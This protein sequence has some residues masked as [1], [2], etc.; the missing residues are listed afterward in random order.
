MPNTL[1]RMETHPRWW[2]ASALLGLFCL[3]GSLAAWLAGEAVGE[4]VGLG[5]LCTI[6][7]FVS[8]FVT[9]HVCDGPAPARGDSHGA[10]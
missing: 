2:R 6:I 7:A 1:K 3:I 8:S 9:H 4:L 10:P 5:S